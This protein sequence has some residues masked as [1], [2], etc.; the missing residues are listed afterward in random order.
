MRRIIRIPFTG[1][2]KLRA[3]LIKAGPADQTPTKVALVR[4]AFQVHD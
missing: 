4:D 3:I 1:A 2:V